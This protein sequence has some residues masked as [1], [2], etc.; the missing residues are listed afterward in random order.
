V[1]ITT[2]TERMQALLGSR[3]DVMR[4]AIELGAYLIG[5][6]IG[7]TPADFDRLFAGHKDAI[8]DAL[9]FTKKKAQ[10]FMQLAKN[11][12]LIR[13]SNWTHLPFDIDAVLALASV[14]SEAIDRA[15]ADGRIH[16]WMSVTAAN[17]L[18]RQ[19]EWGLAR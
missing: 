15:I 14:P 17:R 7:S 3:D 5:T 1:N 18:R 4:N 13:S 9:P 6:K 2:I 8:E 10:G 19:A 12:A 11:A 16:N